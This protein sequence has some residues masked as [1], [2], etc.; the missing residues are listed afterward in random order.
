VASNLCRRGPE[1]RRERRA[2]PDT[3]SYYP[4]R[5]SQLVDGVS[6]TATMDFSGEEFTLGEGEKFTPGR[7]ADAVI[8]DNSLVQRRL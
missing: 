5:R 3:A 6:M 4:G 1:D 8:D 7:E 2:H